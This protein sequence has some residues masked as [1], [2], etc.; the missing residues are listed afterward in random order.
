MLIATAHHTSPVLIRRPFFIQLERLFFLWM[1]APAPN[2]SKKLH[3]I[4]HFAEPL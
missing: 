2:A 3:F 4:F 1:Q